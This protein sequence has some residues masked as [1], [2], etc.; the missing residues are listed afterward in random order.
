M[1][2]S[3]Y[4]KSM[5]AEMGAT[6]GTRYMAQ[7]AIS[8]ITRVIL[9]CLILND[10][11]RNHLDDDQTSGIVYIRENIHH[12]FPCAPDLSTV[13]CSAPPTLSPT[14]CPATPHQILE[15]H[16]LR[17]NEP[18]GRRT[19]KT[20]FAGIRYNSRR[21]EDDDDIRDQKNV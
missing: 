20:T 17:L 1:C 2:R 10:F 15:F 18:L 8:N 19:S 13:G 12:I 16:S 11:L 14:F 4:L 3:W 5:G 9:Y 6:P 21:M 7:C